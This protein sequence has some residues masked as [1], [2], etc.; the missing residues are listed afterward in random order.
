MGTVVS[1]AVFAGD[2]S[3]AT[4]RGAIEEACAILHAADATFS[5]W[6]PASAINRL[7][8]GEAG[9]GEL[10]DEVAEVLDLCLAAHR[11]TRGWFD[12]W[13]LPGG[14]DPTGLVKGWAVARAAAAIERAGV[15]AAMVNGGGDI[16]S[17]GEP[18]PG[19]AWT[20]GVQ[21]PRD[22]AALACTVSLRGAIATSGTYARGDHILDPRTGEPASP[23]AS[24]SVA[25]DDLVVCESY[26]TAVA[27]GGGELLPALVAAGYAACIVEHGG[28]V[29]A[30][31]NFPFAT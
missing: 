16:A 2:V 28:D 21:D 22:E 19:R 20:V 4:A 15:A 24:V 11:R 10:P 12:A 13:A 17:F 23:V 25:G 8:R 27:A 29:R 18:E 9:L 26:A 14:V 31:A 1:F 3:P 7:R 6:K 30:T 5:T